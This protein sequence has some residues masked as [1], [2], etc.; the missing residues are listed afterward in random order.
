MKLQPFFLDDPDKPKGVDWVNAYMSALTIVVLAVVYLDLA[1]YYHVLT[2]GAFLPKHAYF[3]LG[4]AI[5]PLLLV[6]N[7]LFVSYIFTPYVFWVFAF[8]VLNF[9]HWY[10]LSLDGYADLAGVTITRTQFLMLAV[11]I[12]FL[13][14]QVSPIFLGKIFLALAVVLSTLQ[15]IDF[16]MPGTILP[17][18]TE[19]V[20]SGRASATLINANKAAESLVLLAVLGMVVLQPKW[21]IWLLLIVLPGVFLSFS[22]SGLLAL[23]LVF[24]GG[25]WFNLFSRNA[26]LV[27]LALFF[28]L[29]TAVAGLLDFIFSFV[30]V[31]ALDNIYNRIMFFT[32][33]ETS[34][35]SAIERLTVSG[36]AVD[37]FFKEPWFGNGSG[38]THF[39]GI[40][41]QAPHNQHLLV[42][43]EYGI[44][45]YLLFIWLIAMVF[46]GGGYFRKLQSSNMAMIGFA[47]FLV[48]TPFTHN[49]FD[50]LYW[51]IT[52]SIF[53]NRKMWLNK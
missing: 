31:Y 4:A 52:F 45:G 26:Y 27:M 33:L 15:L 44:V 21:R 40:S 19:G 6:R 12:G 2:G 46:C 23:M 9:F 53:T 25:F 24:I 29:V 49:M 13:L 17:L 7:K 48:F 39:W 10:F 30:D 42:M 34:D 11:L 35:S 37:M 32:N 47:V 3:A 50:H 16:F 18:G 8:V 41:D 51:L 5:A 22:R 43:A 20:V 36:Y 28:F 14:V 38:Y 1:N